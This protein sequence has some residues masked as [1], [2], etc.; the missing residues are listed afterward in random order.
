MPLT[1]ESA[2]VTLGTLA[3]DTAA[4]VNLKAD[5]S[6]AQGIQLNRAKGHFELRDVA[7]GEGPIVV[8]FSVGLSGAEIAAAFTADP[9]H[10][11]D[12][13]ASE[14]ANRK[15]FPI[16]SIPRDHDGSGDDGV[17]R[18]W[19]DFRIPRWHVIENQGV[20]VFALN[21]GGTLTTGAT[22]EFAGVIV[23]AWL[24]D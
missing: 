6:R 2:S 4:T 22:L 16:G 18:L 17:V 5:G 24:N 13:D 9:Q 23:F 10:R 3:Q 20:Q 19:R 21:R 11:D 1:H 8:G 7:A 14:A 15:V 12:P